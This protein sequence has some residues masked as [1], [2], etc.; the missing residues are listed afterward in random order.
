MQNMQIGG[1]WSKMV[2]L[3]LVCTGTSI[4]AAMGKVNG[5]AAIGIFGACLGYV[6]GNGHGIIEAKRAKGEVKD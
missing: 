3:I 6:F 2:A 5:D 4:L 1:Q